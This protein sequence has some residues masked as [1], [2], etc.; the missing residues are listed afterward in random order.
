MLAL[1]TSLPELITSIV[2]SRKNHGE[3]A[4]G[5]VF[6]ANVLNLLFVLGVAVLVRPIPIDEATITF[7]M[8]V[9]IGMAVLMLIFGKTKYT[10]M[11]FEGVVLLVA[12]LLYLVALFFMIY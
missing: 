2:S 5:N 10:F 12:Y 9:A 4:M 8:P 7:N 1:G 6:G 3:L 11:R